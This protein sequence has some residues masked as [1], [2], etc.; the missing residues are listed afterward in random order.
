MCEA[1][2]AGARASLGEKS[3]RAK[4]R[5]WGAVSMGQAADPSL[6]H[7]PYPPGISGRGWEQI[8]ATYSS[9]QDQHSK[10]RVL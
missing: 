8:L 1:P 7:L 10:Q 6:Y 3:G 9:S 5:G 2:G 4:V